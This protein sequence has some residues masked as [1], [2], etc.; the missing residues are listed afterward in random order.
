M[1]GQ[2]E[3][4]ATC[5]RGRTLRLDYLLPLNPYQTF[6]HL[7][8]LCRFLLLKF[9]PQTLELRVGFWGPIGLPVFSQ[10]SHPFV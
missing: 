10:I 1:T 5:S 9:G 6:T 3:C 2:P 8:S 4:F 7:D